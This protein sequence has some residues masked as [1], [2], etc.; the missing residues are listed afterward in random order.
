[1]YTVRPDGGIAAKGI[2]SG[3]GFI[4]NHC[5]NYFTDIWLAWYGLPGTLQIR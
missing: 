2:N 3:G 1:V 4:G 5:W